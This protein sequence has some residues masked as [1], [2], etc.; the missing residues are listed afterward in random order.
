[1]I[2][3]ERIMPEN[4]EIPP[5]PI[6]PEGKGEPAGANRPPEGGS[7]RNRTHEPERPET[8][9]PLPEPSSPEGEPPQAEQ[10][11]EELAEKKK[12]H[13]AFVSGLPDEEKGKYAAAVEKMKPQ[14]E[15]ALTPQQTADMLNLAQEWKEKGADPL[16]MLTDA[17][18]VPEEA[19]ALV[20]LS[21]MA[22]ESAKEMNLTPEEQKT[23]LQDMWTLQQ[24]KSELT[25]EKATELQSLADKW[26]EKG[27]EYD[28]LETL[29]QNAGRTPEE[30]KQILGEA[31]E[32]EKKEEKPPIMSEEEEKEM[33]EIKK[34][35]ADPS[36]ADKKG[37]DEAITKG[38]GLL[39]KL[40]ER[41][42]N[43][44]FSNRSIRKFLLYSIAIMLFAYITALRGISNGLA[45][46]GK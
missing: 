6:S 31:P 12:Q 4:G 27:M 32:E 34:L 8:I 46:G 21:E 30:I 2:I 40:M 5:A 28:D 11:A 42:N 14:E 33:E 9:L 24:D 16:I 7:G 13:E 23:H 10:G 41:R 25:P 44:E 18:R 29:L 39:A 36:G 15:E 35:V 26:K 17:G 19:E 45:K 37:V 1:M 22:T 38:K 3:W 43:R 20:G